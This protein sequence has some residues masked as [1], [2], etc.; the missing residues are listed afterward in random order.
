MIS[1]RILKRAATLHKQVS[2]ILAAYSGK[3]VKTSTIRVALNKKLGRQHGV[4]FRQ[5]SVHDAG[6]LAVQ[7][8]FEYTDS[9]HPTSI[10][11]TFFYD[12]DKHVMSKPFIADLCMK[13]VQAM[14][15]ELTHRE[16]H[17]S[18]RKSGKHARG[19]I[20]SKE[21]LAN[22][23]EID[24]YANDVA[25]ELFVKKKTDLLS[26]GSAVSLDECL[27]LAVFY[28]RFGSDTEEYRR[29]NK[30]LY[31]NLAFLRSAFAKVHVEAPTVR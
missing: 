25:Y 23:H 27:H 18:I 1:Q 2:A 31:K 17:K 20:Y 3:T 4:T 14:V 21:Y 10:D 15:H 19:L 24:A 12:E 13:I 9:H 11:I 26:K 28:E 5:F 29:M 8:M 30:K 7:G 6:G 16:Q 22:K